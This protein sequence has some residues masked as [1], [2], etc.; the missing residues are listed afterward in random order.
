MKNLD[1]AHLP[2][3][4]WIERNGS[5]RAAVFD[6]WCALRYDA[7]S[8]IQSLVDDPHRVHAFSDF[9]SANRDLVVRSHNRHFDTIPAVR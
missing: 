8:R 1:M 2:P 7:V 6:L 3:E 9:H 5:D 4:P